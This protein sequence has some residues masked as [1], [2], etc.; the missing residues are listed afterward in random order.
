MGDSDASYDFGSLVA[1]VEK[2]EA[3]YDLVVGNRFSGGIEAGAMPPLHRYFGY[4]LL[5]AIG[6]I[7]YKSPLNDFCCGLRGFGAKRFC[8]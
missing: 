2:L 4:P 6:R 3:G 5:T 7:L 1:F 8:V